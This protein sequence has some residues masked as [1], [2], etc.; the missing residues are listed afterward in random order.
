MAAKHCRARPGGGAGGKA[1]RHQQ[2]NFP[3]APGLSNQG[4]SDLCRLAGAR[5]RDEQRPR[6]VAQRG[7][8]A[9]QHGPDG[10]VGHIAPLP[11]EPDKAP[12]G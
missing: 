4:W 5:R 1:A 2:Q 12:P 11:Q 8:Q 10:K 7:E 9:G 3:R 6:T